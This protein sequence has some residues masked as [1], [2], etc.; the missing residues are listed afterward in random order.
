MSTDGIV[1]LAYE[2][3]SSA[4]IKPII[5]VMY[6]EHQIDRRVFAFHLAKGINEG[7]SYF[8]VGSD[9][10]TAIPDIY[11]DKSVVW[12]NVWHPERKGR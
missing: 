10:E 8:V 4:K 3:A 6:E 7:G 5:D 2:K 1:G 12:N 11:R 9:A